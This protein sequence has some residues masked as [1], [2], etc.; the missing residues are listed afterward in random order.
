MNKNKNSLVKII[1]TAV[2]LIAFALMNFLG[3]VKYE[4]KDDSI[5]VKG[6]FTQVEVP[7]DVINEVT[8]VD[9]IDY[10]SRLGV[11]TFSIVSGTYTNSAYGKY[12]L[13][14][15]RSTT[16]HIVINYDGEILV[17]N[18]STVEETQAAYQ[19]LLEKID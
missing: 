4:L 10:G 14:A 5:N 3:S 6:I 1:I 8:L 13:M 19:S 18:Q 16:K 17:F 2:V 11:S 15:Y 7:Y 12:K 9:D